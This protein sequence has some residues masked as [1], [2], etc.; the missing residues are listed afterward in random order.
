MIKRNRTR[1][2]RPLFSNSPDLY[3]NQEY[4][5]RIDILYDIKMRPFPSRFIKDK[6][7][8]PHT[9]LDV[10]RRHICNGGLLVIMP[11]SHTEIIHNFRFCGKYV[12]NKEW[13]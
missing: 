3:L 2:F 13:P 10:I 11:I 1:A 4:F 6:F 5:L 8:I 9:N 12:Q 7:T